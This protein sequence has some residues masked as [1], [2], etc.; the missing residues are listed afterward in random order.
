MTEG[1]GAP[2]PAATRLRARA[3]GLTRGLFRPGPRNAITDVAGVQVGQVTR[4]E[5]EAIRTGVTGVTALLPHPGNSYTDRVPAGLSVINGFSEMAGATQ[6][7]ELGELE[8][9]IVLTTTLAVGRAVEALVDWTVARNP[10]AVS[11]NAVVGETNDGRLNDI[12]ARGVTAAHVLAALEG[13]G[14]GPVAEAAWTGASRPAGGARQLPGPNPAH[15]VPKSTR[16][17]GMSTARRAMAEPADSKA[18]FRGGSGDTA[19]AFRPHGGLRRMPFRGAAQ[20]MIADW[21][22]DRTSPLFVAAAEAVE[23]A[24]LNA[25]TMA[26]TIIGRDGRTGRHARGRR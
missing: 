19:M 5:G 11:V 26:T 12:R 23:E 4:I 14:G 17:A 15:G 18:A 7:A 20:A 9:P 21:P 13:A 2:A 25:L 3:L 22:N 24:V 8:T 6:L 16:I 10:G 1:A